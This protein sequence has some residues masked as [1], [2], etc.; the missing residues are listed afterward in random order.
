ML[1]ERVHFTLDRTPPKIALIAPS[2]GVV[3]QAV[4]LSAQPTDASSIAK[5]VWEINGETAEVTEAPWN[6]EWTP[7]LSGTYRIRAIA[8]DAAGNRGESSE[9][10]LTVAP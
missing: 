6:T 5:V 9:A 1:E 3:G 7:L 10:V 4:R 8:Y 2:Q